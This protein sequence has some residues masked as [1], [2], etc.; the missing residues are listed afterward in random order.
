M[1]LLRIQGTYYLLTCSHV[2]PVAKN[3]LLTKSLPV[4][5]GPQQFGALLGSP[6]IKDRRTLLRA[7][8]PLAT[9]S[10]KRESHSSLHRPFALED[11]STCTSYGAAG[12]DK[13]QMFG[14]L[15]IAEVCTQPR[16]LAAIS[17]AQP[18]SQ[19]ARER[20]RYTQMAAV[21][22]KVVKTVWWP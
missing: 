14:R 12:V 4:F 6:Y 9:P 17:L 2:M 10:R 16:R 13:R 1:T 15:E 7:G 20:V 5:W 21:M 22:H 3:Y 8:V 19:I 11:I 18:G